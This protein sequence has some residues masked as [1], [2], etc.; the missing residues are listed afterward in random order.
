MLWILDPGVTFQETY[1]YKIGM[2]RLV[3][4]YEARSNVKLEQVK[5][6][7][8]HEGAFSR[9]R[10]LLVLAENAEDGKGMESGYVEIKITADHETT[11]RA[12]ADVKDV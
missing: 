4:T 7:R 1:K 6:K 3:Q 2:N 10:T 5:N 12:I 9:G 8:K 11:R